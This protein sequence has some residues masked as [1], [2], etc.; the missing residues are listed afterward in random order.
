MHK[1]DGYVVAFVRPWGGRYPREAQEAA[2]KAQ[3]IRKV[4]DDRDLLIK[5]QRKKDDVVAVLWLH[6][7]ADPRKKQRRRD[8][9]AA[10]HAIEEK[11]ASVFELGSGRSTRNPRER[12]LM[13]IDA[14]EALGLGRV[15]G[16]NTKPG[17][18]A[19]VFADKDL[20]IIQLHWYSGKHATDAK[21]VEAIRA[22]GV[23]NISGSIIRKMPRFGNS[24]RPFG[25]SKR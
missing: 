18:P 4:Y 16:R 2:A 17:R 1:I 15:P 9:M 24:G 8:M 21:A 20:S 13:I 5:H 7:L 19:R 14:S 25:K 12:D 3:G 6:L 23:K 10:L 22:A 11:G